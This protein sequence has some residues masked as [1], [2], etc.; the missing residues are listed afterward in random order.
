MRLSKYEGKKDI[1]VTI[2][3]PVFNQSHTINR[4][5]DSILSAGNGLKK[6]IFLINDGSTDDSE[7]ICLKYEK[8]CTWGGLE[9]S[10]FQT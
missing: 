2:V 6:Q 3:I 9:E 1:V 7:E 5:M 4:C 10:D 8:E